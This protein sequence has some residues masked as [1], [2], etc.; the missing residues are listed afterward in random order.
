MVRMYQILLKKFYQILITRKKIFSA[1]AQTIKNF[2]FS[3]TL[4][5][6]FMD[7]IFYIFV[8]LLAMFVYSLSPVFCF[9]WDETSNFEAIKIY[10]F[11][12]YPELLSL[13]KK[14][15]LMQVDLE[16]QI[17]QEFA[18][19]RFLLPKVFSYGD[20]TLPTPVTYGR[21][22]ETVGAKARY[23]YLVEHH[24][25]LLLTLTHFRAIFFTLCVEHQRLH[26]LYGL[27]DP[28]IKHK[29]LFLYINRMH[30]VNGKPTH[31][32]FDR[33]NLDKFLDP[34]W[35]EVDLDW[36][37]EQPEIEDGLI[38]I[39]HAFDF[40]RG[41]DGCVE[42]TLRILNALKVRT[43]A[44][45][46]ECDKFVNL[47]PAE[48]REMLELTVEIEK[49]IVKFERKFYAIRKSRAEIFKLHSEWYDHWKVL[50]DQSYTR[51][52]RYFELILDPSERYSNFA[53]I[54]A[55]SL[56]SDFYY[57]LVEHYFLLYF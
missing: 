47:P 40:L 30:E 12:N 50:I 43:K 7:L 56:D 32:D 17:S 26:L 36:V 5:N 57:V 34:N 45:C 52:L 27:E 9:L 24:I 41:E 23:Y 31:P 18:E 37:N 20:D 21:F 25:N 44:F 14:N 38:H 42:L 49:L 10:Y 15:Q 33:Y 46:D 13:L 1:A 55:S 16:F 35:N 2:S 48:R 29:L 39:Y 54:F 8:V 28:T 51:D 3:Q 11:M 22:C 53:Y 6:P 19:L 4:K